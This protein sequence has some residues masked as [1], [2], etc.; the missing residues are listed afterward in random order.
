MS[1]GYNKS[2]SGIRDAKYAVSSVTPSPVLALIGKYSAA[3]NADS[4]CSC[5]SIFAGSVR[6]I[7][8]KITTAFDMSMWLLTYLSPVPKV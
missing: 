6:S 5:F 2:P 3:P 7:L 4:A 8:F 1:T